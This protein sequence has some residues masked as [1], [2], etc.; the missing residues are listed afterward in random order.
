MSDLAA[1]LAPKSDQI[2]ASD[3]LAG[4]MVITIT[5]VKITPGT[6]QPV[7]ISFEG[8]DKVWRPCKTTGRILMAAWGPDTSKYAGRSVHLYLD[9][10]V[11]WGG[12][13]VGGIR[14]RAVSHI[15]REMTL[16][17]A[18][19]KANR[20][21]F[22]VGV[23]QAPAPTQDQPAPATLDEARAIAR[24]GKAAFSEWWTQNPDKRA[25]AK[26]ILP[27]LQRLCAEADA[28]SADPFG[29]PPTEPARATDDE[30]AAQIADELAARDAELEGR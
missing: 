15:D 12:M 7:S 25:A 28:I 20:K 14:I 8:S 16:M 26:T 9:P 19:S 13:E 1:V 29:L 6:E 10:K 17:L 22:R 30:I 3:L 5:G 4:D 21:P 23:L 2:N 18:E 11:K 24:K 27:E